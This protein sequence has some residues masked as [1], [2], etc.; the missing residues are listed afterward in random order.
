MIA[1]LIFT[2][3]GFCFVLFAL[4]LLRDDTARMNHRKKECLIYH[5]FYSSYSHNVDPHCIWCKVLST[6]QEGHISAPSSL[7]PD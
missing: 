6:L 3:N 7:Q 1:N 4:K 5:Y 2:E